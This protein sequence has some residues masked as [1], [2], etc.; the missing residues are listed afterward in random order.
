[1]SDDVARSFGSVC[2]ESTQRWRGTTAKAGSLSLAI[3]AAEAPSTSHRESAAITSLGIAANWKQHICVQSSVFIWV[4][5]PIV[6]IGELHQHGGEEVTAK[7]VRD[8]LVDGAV[9][10]E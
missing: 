7:M 4:A 8:D 10:C 1:M 3:R 5:V 6:G 2:Q 9:T